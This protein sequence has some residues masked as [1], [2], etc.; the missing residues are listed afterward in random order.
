LLGLT[1]VLLDQR[2]QPTE[3]DGGLPILKMP[4][5]SITELQVTRPDEETT[6]IRKVDGQWNITA[7]IETKADNT[8]VSTAVRQ[9]SETGVKT[10]VATKPEHYTRLEVD[11]SQAVHVA[12][13]HGSGE[14][15]K[16]SIGKYA[17]GY[18]MARV[19]DSESV[20]GLDGEFLPSLD[21]PLDDWRDTKII[22]TTPNSATQILYDTDRG[23]W[24]FVRDLEVTDD[25]RWKQAEGEEPIENFDARRVS[26]F[27]STVANLRAIGFAE[28]GVDATEAGL[29]PPLG[30]ITLTATPGSG[31]L[32][33]RPDAEPAKAEGPEEP[34]TFVLEIGGPAK[35]EQR[36]YV[37]RR[38]DDTIY[39]ISGHTHGRLRPAKSAFQVKD[40]TSS[41]ATA[42]NAQQIPAELVQ[43]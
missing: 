15:T 33:I 3:G 11:P 35:E 23:R 28:K 2:D 13:T 16:L 30:L 22:D 10:V 5:T 6:V 8:A 26:G 4:E 39:I 7:P 14:V 42:P 19:N 41:P 24:R 17:N 36:F 37:R 38:G 34:Q 25:I 21:R 1:F 18:T 9:L 20:Y 32:V 40:E 12:V 27:V 31:S 43:Q 29:D